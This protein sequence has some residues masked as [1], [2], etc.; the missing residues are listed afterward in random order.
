MK[1]TFNGKLQRKPHR[2]KNTHPQDE[3]KIKS[4]H[5]FP[6]FKFRTIYPVFPTDPFLIRNMP[7]CFSD[8]TGL[9]EYRIVPSRRTAY[10][11]PQI[12][13]VLKVRIVYFHLAKIKELYHY[14]LANQTAVQKFVQIRHAIPSL[15]FLLFLK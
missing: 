10:Q 11:V 9:L 6:K 5:Y 1:F 13:V 2:I 15:K 3:Q 14:Y 8:I 7:I 12:K 4:R